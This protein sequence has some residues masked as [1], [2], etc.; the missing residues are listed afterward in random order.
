MKMKLKNIFNKKELSYKIY[1]TLFLIYR[2]GSFF[3]IPFRKP[4]SIGFKSYPTAEGILPNK[5][6]LTSLTGGACN[7]ASIFSLGIMPN[8]S[9]SIF[10]QFLCYFFKKLKVFFYQNCF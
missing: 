7:R 9:A 2:F 5:N 6:I 10:I 3:P 8:L 4:I 1:Y